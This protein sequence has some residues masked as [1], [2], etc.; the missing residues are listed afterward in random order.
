MQEPRE[1]EWGGWADWT[2]VPA[3]EPCLPA[4]LA[5]CRTHYRDRELMVWQE[6]LPDRALRLHRMSY[7]EM[8]TESAVL[9]R[10][11]LRAGIGK[12]RALG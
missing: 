11:L 1:R 2:N 7:G 6:Q 10:R 3:L 8:D 5:H 9:A 4:L 12:G